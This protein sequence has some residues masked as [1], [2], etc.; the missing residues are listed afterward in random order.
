MGGAGEAHIYCCAPLGLPPSF[1]A[2]VTWEMRRTWWAR[3]AASDL[4]EPN[5][6]IAKLQWV[7]G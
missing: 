3:P 5:H 2:W 4:V 6:L 1:V 7:F